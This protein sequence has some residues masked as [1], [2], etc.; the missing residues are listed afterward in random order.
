MKSKTFNVRKRFLIDIVLITD[1]TLIL[2]YALTTSNLHVFI[3]AALTLNLLQVLIWLFWVSPTM[4]IYLDEQALTGPSQNLKKTTIPLD[5]IDKWRTE[6][7]RGATKK[8]G[9]VD[10]YSFEGSRVRLIRPV[11]GRGQ[12]YIILE[13]VLG[14]LHADSPKIIV[15]Y[16]NE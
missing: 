9:Y 2:L 12:C 11:L 3:S 15:P 16:P 4:K 6:S 1:V 10:I 13:S 5:K 7:L 8:K 14:N